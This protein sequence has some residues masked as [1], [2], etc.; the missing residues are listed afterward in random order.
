[1]A[2]GGLPSR[3][4]LREAKDNRGRKFQKD[5]QKKEG[6]MSS[7]KIKIAAA[8]AAI[9]VVLSACATATPEVIEKVVTKEI[10]KVV[11]QIVKETVKETVIVEGTPQV[12]EKEVTKIVEEVVVVTATPEPGVGKEVT[13][14]VGKVVVV[15]GTKFVV[16]ELA[17]V[18][19]T[20]VPVWVQNRQ[21]LQLD[22]IETETERLHFRLEIDT[23]DYP[24]GNDFTLEVMAVPREEIAEI[25]QGQKPCEQ[26]PE[27]Y[28]VTEDN[29]LHIQVTD[30]SV[31]TA[32]NPYAFSVTGIDPFAESI[33]ASISITLPQSTTRETLQEQ[34]HGVMIYHEGDEDNGEGKAERFSAD[35]I[36]DAEDRRFWRVRNSDPITR[37]CRMHG[38]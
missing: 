20:P 21:P 29:Y 17:D 11:T 12:V 16:L 36:T 13:I 27:V 7:K 31:Y 26:Y 9:L 25:C 2:E 4:P 23:D 14:E 15:G 24:P 28:D 5:F 8:L 37:C 19:E 34:E 10:E 38:H 30:T 3:G 35:L 33:T 1:M 32:S 18:I 22:V 6:E